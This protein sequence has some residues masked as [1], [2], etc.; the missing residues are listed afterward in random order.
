MQNTKSHNVNDFKNALSRHDA[1]A[2]LV[3]KDF[4]NEIKNENIYMG[5]RRPCYV[6]N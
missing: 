1:S 3:S 6:I 4:R 2:R 5:N